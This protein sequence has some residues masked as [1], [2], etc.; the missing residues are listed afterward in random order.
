MRFRTDSDRL[1]ADV[2]VHHLDA[3]PFAR[4]PE[5]IEEP[6]PVVADFGGIVDRDNCAQFG[7]PVHR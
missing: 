7:I 2:S 4:L 1:I 6:V 5:V 3:F